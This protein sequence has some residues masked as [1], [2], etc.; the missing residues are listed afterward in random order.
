M[1]SNDGVKAGVSGIGANASRVG[2]LERVTGRQLYVADLPHGDALHVKLVTVDA[3][4]AR[5]DVIDGTR[6]RAVPGVHLVMTPADLPQPMPRFG[7][8]RRDRPVLAVGETKY[9]GEPV[10][11]VAAE[12]LD[13]AEE[14]VG[15]VRVEYQEMPAVHTI[16]ASL[17]P[18]APL[19]QD[20]SLRPADP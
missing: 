8:Q 7:P 11:A 3:A 19:V 1:S 6:A 16:E 15:L 9:H 2:G 12:T 13:A 17:A 20:P 10:A 18:D 14:A 5:V 4:R